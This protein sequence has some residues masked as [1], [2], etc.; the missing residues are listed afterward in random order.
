MSW[1]PSLLLEEPSSSA[2]GY[3]LHHGLCLHFLKLG[4]EEVATGVLEFNLVAAWLAGS[5]SAHRGPDIII[6]HQRQNQPACPSLLSAARPI[7]PPWDQVCCF[8][9]FLV[10]FFHDTCKYWLLGLLSVGL[11][12]L[13]YDGKR[14]RQKKR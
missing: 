13:S 5:S 12:V 8:A 7:G 10:L 11:G 9:G 1:N 3:L 14:G 2:I 6:F 4:S